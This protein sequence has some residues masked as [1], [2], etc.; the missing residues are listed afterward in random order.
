MLNSFKIYR[1]KVISIEEACF[2]LTQLKYNRVQQVGEPGDFAL[3]GDT[4]ELFPINF[5]HP[6]RI[7]WEFDKVVK[8]YSFDQDF[9]KLLEY[10]LL[11]VIPFFKKAP[12][13]KTEDIPLEGSLR[14]KAGDYV[15]HTHYG[16]GRFLGVK[17]IKTTQR[18]GYFFQ[19]EYAKGDKIYVSKEKAHLI[20][21]YLNF[22]VRQ[23]IL[24]KLGTKQWKI[25][26]EKV[27]KGIHSYAL[28]ILKME[29]QRKLIGGI[30][31]PK[32]G[33]WQNKFEKQFPYQL[34]PD[35]EKAAEIVKKEM[36]SDKPMDR[37][38]CGGVG[39]GKT[40]IAMRAAFRAATSGYQ[41]AFLVPTTIL[42]YQHFISLQKRMKDFPLSVEMLSRFRSRLQQ[43]KV[44][45]RIKEGKVDV[46]VGTHR[47]LSEDVKFRELGLLIIDEEQRFGVEHKERIKSY[48]AGVGV[49]TLTATPIPRTLY[50]GM[51]GI[52]DISLIQTPP[53]ERMAIK[54]KV[55]SFSVKTIKKAVQKELKRGG[56]VFFVHNRIQDIA[57]IAKKL[58]NNLAGV[59]I[60]VA[61]GRLSPAKIEEV[62]LKFID[63]EIDVLVSTSIVESGIDIPNANTIIINNAHN[64]GLADLH[65]LRGRVGRYKQQAYAF[66]LRPP[67]DTIKTESRKRLEFIEE[68]SHLGAGFELARRD[69]ELRGAG[70]LLG[71]QQHG[72]IWMV[73]FDLYCRL[74]KKEV[75][76]LREAFKIKE[77]I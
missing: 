34:T 1:H 36:Q 40:E 23:P 63:K 17:K 45:Q 28:S 46:V 65:Q 29:A 67:L 39:Y 72:F 37:L 43:E 5:S 56:Q 15:V 53:K 38:L 24:T 48:R 71:K 55:S 76:Y 44:I 50:M 22:K 26:K 54:T 18:E 6:V 4:L 49:L 66:C 35:Q 31:Y 10:D 33:S 47:I 52:K 21:K 42:A 41:V 61:H 60:E 25:T 12:R 27:K 30:S 51:V 62:M 64:F 11:I 8:I 75:D 32:D 19:I 7:E 70:N 13:Y 59:R 74:L 3:K 57:V 20:Q 68:F 2:N 58:K 73:G 14:I 9:S 77:K 16:I 69:L